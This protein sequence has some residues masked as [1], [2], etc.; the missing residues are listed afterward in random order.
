MAVSLDKIVSYT[1]FALLIF[2]FLAVL[3]IEAIG[4]KFNDLFYLN[5]DS[6]FTPGIKVIG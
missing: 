4:C 2:V 3:I 6:L 1:P 5:F